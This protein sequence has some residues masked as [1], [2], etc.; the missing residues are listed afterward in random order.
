[1][2]ANIRMAQVLAGFLLAL[3]FAAG[4]A[5]QTLKLPPH[6]KV[7]LKNGLTVLLMEKHG[8][9]IINVAAIVKA[10]SVADPAGQEGL[11]S[12]TA[13]LLRKGTAKRSAKQFAEDIDFIGGS[14]DADAG[15]DFT[16]ISGEFL[17]KDLDR[18]L[19]LF[20]DALLHP[21]FTQAEVDKMLAQ[22]IDGVKAAK[23]EA[24]SVAITY[25]YG[26]LFAKH[27]YARPEGGD[28]LS[29]ARIKRD[30]IA[31][32]Y[33]VNYTP[34]NTIL[35]VA[36]DFNASQMRAKI[37]QS[38]SGWL[39][40]S[41]A[42]Q[43][44]SALPAVKGKRML[45]VDKP[46]S[47]QTFFAFG[48]VGTA[49]NEPDRVA[50]R[51]VNTI[52]G[53]RFTS[54]LNEALRVESGLTYGASSFFDSKKEP[55]AFAIYSYT[56]NETTV[57]A[58]DLALQVLDKLHKDGVTAEQLAS[59][60]AYLKGQFPPAIETSA[61]LARRIASNEFYGLGD[62]EINQLEARIDAVTPVLAKQVIEKHFPEDNLVFMLIG[63]A[64]EIGPAVQKYATQHDAR[65]I[66]EPGFWPPP[67]K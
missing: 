29:L 40:R 64:S 55:G 59:A 22:D 2:S 34:G 44:V 57:Q 17:T 15:A 4:A 52:F 51:V 60:K 9:P 47:T 67:G 31:K 23:D 32:F 62:D 42:P 30:A 58:I 61:Q 24:Q 28:E 13:G 1:M 7:V 33:E 39:A 63:K 50:L 54:E 49:A 36:G 12:I 26:Y 11:A 14:F 45:L 21:A 53:G 10:G 19:D 43:T 8:V 35:A 18:G 20:S 25:Y 56:K 37:E 65:K 27:P 66:N 48:N 38:L 46:D 3:G 16:S 5:A 6:E 41:S